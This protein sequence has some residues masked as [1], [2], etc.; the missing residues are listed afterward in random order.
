MTGGDMV[1]LKE[2][3]EAHLGAKL[4]RRDAQINGRNWGEVEVAGG[5][6]HF[7][8]DGKTS[9][10]VSAKDISACS[11]VS[12]H[13]VMMEFHIDDGAAK[14]GGPRWHQVEHCLNPGLHT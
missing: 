6:V 9:F 10:E 14:V 2:L 11:M 13:E 12:K 1:G 4:A 3:C 5:T 7:G 8:V